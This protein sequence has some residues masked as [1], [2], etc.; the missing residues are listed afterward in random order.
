MGKDQRSQ[1]PPFAT[2][3]CVHGGMAGSFDRAKAPADG[4][5]GGIQWGDSEPCRL[6]TIEDCPMESEY[7]AVRPHWCRFQQRW[8]SRSGAARWGWKAGSRG[9]LGCGPQTSRG[10]SSAG[11]PTR[12]L[13]VAQKHDLVGQGNDAPWC[14]MMTM[15]RPSRAS[16][17]SRNVS[18]SVEAPQIDA[19]LGLVVDGQLRVAG[20]KWWR[21]RCASPRRP[22][23]T[24]PPRG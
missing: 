7:P 12:H 18:V 11:V 15:E 23:A 13:A 9:H 24:C 16:W 1:L 21:S 2:R 22:T 8:G 3:M 14:E 17:M 19:G 4:V 20:P 6:D 10:M 5:E